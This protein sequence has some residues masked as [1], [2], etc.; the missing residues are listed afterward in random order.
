LKCTFH[1]LPINNAEAIPG[2][3]IILYERMFDST[4][5]ES[6]LVAVIAHEIAH[7]LH[8][9]FMKFWQDYKENGDVDG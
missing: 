2:G 3:Q 4:D 1:R 6:Q 7:E 9:D 8:N 5:N